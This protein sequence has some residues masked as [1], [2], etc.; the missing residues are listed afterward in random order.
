MSHFIGLVFMRPDND[1]EETLAPFD[2]QNEDYFEFVDKTDEVKAEYEKLPDTCPSGG[3]YTEIIDRTDLV[4]EIWDN[5]V[6][7]LNPEDEKEFWKPY[8]KKDYPTP[9]DIAKDKNY[10]IVPD[11]TKRNGLRFEQKVER[12]W[13]Y[14][15]SKEKYPTLKDYAT[16]YHGYTKRAGKYGYVHNPNAKWDWYAEDGGRWGAFLKRKDGGM[17]SVDLLTEIDWESDENVPFCF[18]NAEGEW[19]EKG[20]MGWWGMTSNEKKTKDWHTEFKEYVRSLLADPEAEDIEVY[21]VDF[22]I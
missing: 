8:T 17:T 9:A 19:I 4:N 16:E 12:N 20:E 11:E 15:P 18:V 22:H 6:D 1:L 13:E 3:T 10:D 14:Q 7:E 2:E 5:A 21:A